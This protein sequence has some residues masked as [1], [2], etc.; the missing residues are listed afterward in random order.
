MQHKQ[1]KT[2]H[3]LTICALALSALGTSH[4][5]WAAP[6][7]NLMIEPGKRLGRVF[8]GDTPGAVRRRLGKPA[9]TFSLGAGTTSE[10]WRSGPYKLEV[11]YKRG[12]VAQIEATNPV[13]Q[14]AEDMGVEDGAAAWMDAMG[15]SYA[16]SIYSYPNKERQV[17]FDWKRAGLSLETDGGEGWERVMTVIVHRAGSSVIPDRGGTP[18]ADDEDEH[19]GH[20]H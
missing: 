7:D 16:K 10:L 13:F 12:K 18:I 3:A 4:T 20:G 2:A 15:S 5:A 14:T 1:H 9:R 17:Y 11:V 19:E 8:L 6:K